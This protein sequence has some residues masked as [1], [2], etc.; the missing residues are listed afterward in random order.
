MLPESARS[1]M[2][3]PHPSGRA[4]MK[5]LEQEG[6]AFDCYIDI[7]DGGPTMSVATDQ[8]RTIREAR[9][10]VFAG[11]ADD[12]EGTPHI[13]ASGALADFTACYGRM[14]TAPD[15]QAWLD[16]ATAGSLS[17]K[18]GETFLAMSR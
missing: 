13:V 12:L 1:V 5:M 16:P 4:A 8:V 6:F 10:L 14:R 2:G 11:T 17:I 7:F 15:N 9:E 18:P 3:V